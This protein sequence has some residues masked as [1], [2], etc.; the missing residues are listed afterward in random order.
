[1]NGLCGGRGQPER[2]ELVL[3]FYQVGLQEQ[4]QVVRLGDKYLYIGSHLSLPV[5]GNLGVVVHTCDLSPE[6]YW[7]ITAGLRPA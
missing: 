3:S 5:T 4:T 6:A 1:M 7:M 2:G